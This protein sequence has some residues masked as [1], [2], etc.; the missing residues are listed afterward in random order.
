[1]TGHPDVTFRVNCGSR[2]VA[3]MMGPATRWGRRDESMKSGISGWAAVCDDRCR[4]RNH[5]LEGIK[6]DRPA[7]DVQCIKSACITSAFSSAVVHPEVEVVKNPSILGFALIRRPG[8]VGAVARPAPQPSRA[9]RKSITVDAE[10]GQ[11]RSPR[12]RRRRNW[13]PEA[14]V[15]QSEMAP[16]QRWD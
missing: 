11:K 4:S 7:Q 5:G 3:H 15:L 8:T 14:Q 12:I 1:M 2:A 6:R 9:R 16:G 10:Q 13:P